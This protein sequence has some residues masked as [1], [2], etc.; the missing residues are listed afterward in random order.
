VFEQTVT[1]PVMDPGVAGVGLTVTAS[2]CTVE[3]PQVLLA[4]TVTFPLDEPAVA[5]ME[6]VTD[7][8]VQ[9]DGNDHV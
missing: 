5:L 7:D 2:V 6:F 4:T 1:L 3:E 9:P 8:P